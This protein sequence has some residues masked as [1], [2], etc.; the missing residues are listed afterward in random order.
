MQEL[1]N[2]LIE[3]ANLSPEDAA[4]A[5]QTAVDFVKSK[6]P[7]FFGDKIEELING[8]FDLGSLMGGFGGGGDAGE[9]PLDKLG[10]MFGK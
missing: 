5:A 8:K 7:P 10:S 1:I 9:S 6:V 4:K 3:K 2:A